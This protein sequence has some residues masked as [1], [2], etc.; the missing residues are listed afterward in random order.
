MGEALDTRS[1][2]GMACEHQRTVPY[3]AFLHESG[4]YPDRDASVAIRDARSDLFIR[5]LL[6]GYGGSRHEATGLRCAYGIR[7]PG[8]PIRL[9]P[10]LIDA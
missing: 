3:R 9:I 4:Q 2:A 6:G 1:A 10:S 5:C 8:A 7:R